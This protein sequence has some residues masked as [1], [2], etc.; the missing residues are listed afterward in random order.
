MHVDTH[1]VAPEELERACRDL[2]AMI[3][4]A[5]FDPAM[6]TGVVARTSGSRQLTV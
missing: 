3:V 4:E 2:E 5:A 6:T 1:A